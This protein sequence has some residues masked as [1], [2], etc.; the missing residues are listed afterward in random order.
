MSKDYNKNGFEITFKKQV[1]NFNEL[2]CH[3]E[4]K[5]KYN[6]Y[7]IFVWQNKLWRLEVGRSQY[8]ID[9]WKNHFIDFFNTGEFDYY[10]YWR[11]YTTAKND[12]YT[13]IYPEDIIY[14]VPLSKFAKNDCYEHH[15]KLMSIDRTDEEGLDLISKPLSDCTIQ[16]ITL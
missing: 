13:H 10:G 11:K 15:P 9:K 16:I 14:K 8:Y 1:P 2:I 3:F 6:T 4:H 12:I 7:I 5:G